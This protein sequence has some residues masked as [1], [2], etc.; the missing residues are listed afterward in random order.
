MAE[1]YRLWA[2]EVPPGSETDV[3]RVK[4][5]LSFHQADENVIIQANIDSFR[6]L[7]ITIAQRDAHAELRIGFSER[8]RYGQRSNGRRGNGCVYKRTDAGRT[9]TGPTWQRCERKNR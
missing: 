4:Q 8:V 1:V 6:E 9:N 2:I 7:Q 3:E 5:I